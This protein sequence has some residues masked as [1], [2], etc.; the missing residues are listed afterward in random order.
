[1]AM[2][3]MLSGCLF[4]AAAG[5]LTAANTTTDLRQEFH[6]SYALSPNGRVA[7]VNPY[8]DVRITGWDRNE[9]RIEAVKT[10]EAG[11]RLEDAFILVDATADRLSVRTQYAGRDAER[12]ANVE[13]RI[14]VPR[15][16]NL[17]EVRVVN[18]AL[19]IHGVAGSVKATSVNG[20][21]TAEKLGGMADLATIN[22]EVEAGFE[23]LISCQPISLR[24]VNG[25]IGLSLP[26][27]ARAQ[28]LAQNRSGNIESDLG[29]T[30]RQTA[31]H[32]Y[33]AVL[34]G[35]GTSIQLRNVTGGISIHST[36]SRRHEKPEL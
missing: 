10:A 34:G 6:R 36:W 17:D 19:S 22:G 1:M 4:L 35:G 26:A 5:A 2:K 9:V 12:P 28:L 25:H 33:Q 13:Y 14:S 8:G 23:R 20:N 11:G 27:G 3:S 24:S 7:I 32:R 30:A 21:I 15:T 18:G 31:G 16:A 29:R